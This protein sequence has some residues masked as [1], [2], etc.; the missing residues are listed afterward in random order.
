MTRRISEAAARAAFERA[1][2]GEQ[3]VFGDFFLFRLLG[4][5]IRQD[6]NACHIGF[7]AADFLFNPQGTLHGGIIGTALDI[8]M[9]HR[10]NH[11]AGPGTTLEFKV[12]F[13]GAIRGGR[14]SCRGE[15]LKQGRSI[16]FLR[17]EARDAAGE[18]VAH[19]TST[20]KLLSR[21]A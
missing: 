10:L 13:T 5:E 8:A 20:W 14:V 2:A 3:E 17:A 9:G 16:C 11:V 7:E 1:L 12:Q 18:L 19:A 6:E 4:L 21:S 15:M